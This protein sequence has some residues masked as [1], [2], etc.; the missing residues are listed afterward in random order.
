MHCKTHH[1]AFLTKGKRHN[2]VYFVFSL[3][4]IIYL[5]PIWGI[6]QRQYSCAK[7]PFF[8]KQKGFDTLRT[9]LSTA[10]KRYMG[11][12][13][14]EL[15]KK[16]APGEQPDLNNERARYYQHPSWKSAGY[17]ASITLDRSGNAYAIPA[18]HISLLYNHPKQQ[19]KIYRVDSKTGIMLPWMQLPIPKV[20]TLQNAYGLLGLTYDCA[21][22]SIFAATVAGSTRTNEQGVLLHISTH[23]KKVLDTL[24]GI[25]AMGLAVFQGVKGE[26][27]LY[28]GK[29]R[30]GEVY[31]VGIG[32][33]G[34]FLR[35]SVR[36]ECS[37][38]GIGPRG[39]DA[40]RKIRFDRDLMI[41]TGIAF[42][43]NLQASSEK[44]E[45]VYVYLRDPS[46]KTWQLI[47]I[48]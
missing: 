13:L 28:F 36:L 32:A 4:I 31:S 16:P 40:P 2:C 3:L 42:N 38:S 8:V 24:K 1:P 9:A 27:R 41:V 12:V 23:D 35:G 18:P 17:L 10:E 29:I 11:L 45:T 5:C 48:Q 6:A 39:D 7:V 14:I 37:V 25:D 33:D 44:P 34:K 21:D 19:N 20:E 46:A 26:R 47:N 30:T 15:A 43:Y 22:G